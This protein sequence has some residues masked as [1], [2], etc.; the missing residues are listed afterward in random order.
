MEKEEVEKLPSVSE[1]NETAP[2]ITDSVEGYSIFHQKRARPGEIATQAKR[3]LGSNH[4]GSDHF[5]DSGKSLAIGY[6]FWN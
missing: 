6:F 3:S 2:K 1:E 5:D 4:E